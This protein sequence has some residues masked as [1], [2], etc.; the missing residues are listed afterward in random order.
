MAKSGHEDRPKLSIR[1]RLFRLK[2][3]D[4]LAADNDGDESQ[5]KVLNLKLPH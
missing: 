2:K 5:F 4:T 3:V 1:E